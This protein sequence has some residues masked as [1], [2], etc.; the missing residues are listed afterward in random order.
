MA[1]DTKTARNQP[2]GLESQY[3]ESQV[4]PGNP[5]NATRQPRR[6]SR[7]QQRGQESPTK[8]VKKGDPPKQENQKSQI[9]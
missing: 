3:S 1:E 9:L 5:S 7:E 6:R 4:E 8:N 2:P